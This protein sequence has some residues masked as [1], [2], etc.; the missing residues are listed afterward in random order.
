MKR[1]PVVWKTLSGVRLI[2]RNDSDTSTPTALIFS[3]K[4]SNSCCA[5]AFTVAGA[6]V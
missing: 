3:T 5:F 1:N 4:V 2:H 6:N